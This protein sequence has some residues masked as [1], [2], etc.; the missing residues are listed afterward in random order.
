[1]TRHQRSKSNKSPTADKTIKMRIKEHFMPSSSILIIFSLLCLT[2]SRN[3][4]GKTQPLVVVN[5]SGGRVGIGEV[6][7]TAAF[8]DV[9]CF[10]GLVLTILFVECW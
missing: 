4:F 5:I 9:C 3:C 1:M 6:F 7:L 2:S 10:V 8:V